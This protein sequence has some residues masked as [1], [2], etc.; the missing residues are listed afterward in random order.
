MWVGGC[1]RALYRLCVCVM[2]V[3]TQVLCG[4]VV[5][6]CVVCVVVCIQ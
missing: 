6:Q 1:L 4:Y 2:C 5:H 3:A